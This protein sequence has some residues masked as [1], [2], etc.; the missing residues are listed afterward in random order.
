KL[1]ISHPVRG[2]PGDVVELDLP[3]SVRPGDPVLLAD[4]VM[5]LEVL[6][7]RRC[8]VIVGGGIPAGKGMNLPSSRLDLPSLTAKDREALR[9]GVEAGVAFV[10][11]SFVRRATDL[12]EP[13]ASG[14][15]VIAKIE[16]AEAVERMDELA[17]AADGIMIARGDLGVE[18]PIERVPIVQK[19]LIAL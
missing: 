5:Q 11:L 16:T 6:D 4:G 12:E 10:S 14:L 2:V 1:R 9:F 17:A 3:P 19:Q 8:R 15:P 7:G 18:V 13:R